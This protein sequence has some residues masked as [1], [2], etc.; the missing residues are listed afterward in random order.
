MLTRLVWADAS[1]VLC[2]AGR[3]GEADHSQLCG[4]AELHPGACLAGHQPAYPWHTPSQ[5]THRCYRLMLLHCLA[6]Q[7]RLITTMA[8]QYAKE[9]VSWTSTS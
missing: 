7:Y 8:C 1:Y 3:A 6:V 4:R 5:H 9:P 2:A